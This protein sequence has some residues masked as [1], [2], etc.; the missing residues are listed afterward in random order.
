MKHKSN[1]FKNKTVMIIDD[2]E[3]D[4]FINEKMIKS[5]CFSENVYTNTGTNSALDFFK[6]L[7][8]LQNLPSELIPSYIFLDINMPI[9]DGFHFLEEFE[10]LPYGFIKNIKIVMLTTSLNPSDVE[11][12]K[13]Y[14]SVVGYLY[15]PL[16]Q[17]DLDKLV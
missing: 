4:N 17:E 6:N 7:S 10:N 13:P 1:T 3:I 11:R 16:I 14:K 5:C 15:K 9:L 2:N 8:I 12:T